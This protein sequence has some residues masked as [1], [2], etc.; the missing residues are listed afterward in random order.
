MEMVT[1]RETLFLEEEEEKEEEEEGTQR[2]GW[3]VTQGSLEVILQFCKFMRL[4]SI[5]IPT[6]PPARPLSSFLILTQL[7]SGQ[8]SNSTKYIFTLLVRGLKPEGR[9]SGIKCFLYLGRGMTK[10]K[11][12]SKYKLCLFKAS[13]ECACMCVCV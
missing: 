2:T 3:G 8:A 11:T 6:P 10:G 9:K 5:F 12:Q 4:G 13:R 1:S 7:S